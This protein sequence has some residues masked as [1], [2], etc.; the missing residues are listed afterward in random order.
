[1]NKNEHLVP[2]QIL[3]MIW[4]LQQNLGTNERMALM[5]RLEVTRD[6]ITNALAKEL[7]KKGK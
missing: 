7:R 6:F 2:P 1:V 5:Q 4:R 3:D